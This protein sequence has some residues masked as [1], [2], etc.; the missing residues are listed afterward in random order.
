MLKTGKAQ[1]RC[2]YSAEDVHA[3][4][5]PA[6]SHARTSK[7]EGAPIIAEEDKDGEGL[8]WRPLGSLGVRPDARVHIRGDPHQ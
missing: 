8:G 5:M 3:H 2:L 4:R 6:V 7:Q 1:D